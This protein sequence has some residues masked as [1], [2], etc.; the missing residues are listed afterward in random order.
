MFLN[1]R[2]KTLAWF[3]KNIVSLFDSH[4]IVR[5]NLIDDS[6][7]KQAFD[8]FDKRDYSSA[9]DM[10]LKEAENG[11]PAAQ[12]NIGL[13]YATNSGVFQNDQ[14]TEQW[15]RKASEQGLGKAQYGLCCMLAAD[16]MTGQSIL[17]QEDQKKTMVEAFMW[18]TIANEQGYSES[19]EAIPRV[20]AHMTLEQT[21]EASKLARKWTEDFKRK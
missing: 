21:T 13:C 19:S 14:A 2:R 1:L 17:S 20:K 10:F 16:I 3:T 9:F 4:Y 18:L 11:N 15:Y 5:N 7:L 8:A 6:N 12:Y